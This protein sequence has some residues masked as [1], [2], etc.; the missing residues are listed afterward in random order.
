[1]KSI[2]AAIAALAAVA[3]AQSS[4][5]SVTSPLQGTTWTAGS[6][7]TITWYENIIMVLTSSAHTQWF[8]RIN[9]TVDTISKI[10]LANGQST[11]LQQVM[12]VAENVSAADGSYT[13]NVP[14]DLASGTDC[15]FRKRTIGKFKKGK[16]HIQVL[17][18]IYADALEFGSS[19]D[20]AYSPQFT[21]TSSSSSGSG[22]STQ[23]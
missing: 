1:M 2:I 9:P 13:W 17:T 19:P 12:V 16:E 5:V 20:V 7:A 3:S 11:A 8:S 15:K 10:V 23:E 21:I 14:T 22:K 4:I 18:S 6:S